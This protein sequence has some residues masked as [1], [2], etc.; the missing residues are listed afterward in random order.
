MTLNKLIMHN[1]SSW[2]IWPFSSMFLGIQQHQWAE[3]ACDGYSGWLFLKEVCPTLSKK[4]QNNC[5]TELIIIENLWVFYRAL[6]SEIHM[7]NNFSIILY[8]WI[9][10]QGSYVEGLDLSWGH[11]WGRDKHEGGILLKGSNF[12]WYAFG[13]YVLCPNPLCLSLSLLTAMRW[14]AS[15]STHTSCD[16][17]HPCR[18]KAADLHL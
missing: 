12:L 14:A 18:P 9:F 7:L 11:T 4:Q 3:Q 15:Y 10:S 17:L 1:S 2:T 16:V 6:E 5:T 8:I 13:Q